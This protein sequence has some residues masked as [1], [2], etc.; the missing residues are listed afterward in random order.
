MTW[1]MYE[2]FVSLAFRLLAVVCMLSIP[3][4]AYCS[5][6]HRRRQRVFN[7]HVARLLELLAKDQEILPAT[8][9]HSELQ[10]RFRWNLQMARASRAYD[11]NPYQSPSED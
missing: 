3:W 1:E 5:S 10:E 6:K 2:A 7:W 4:D 9:I 11:L 8:E